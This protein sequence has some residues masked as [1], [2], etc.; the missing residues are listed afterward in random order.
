MAIYTLPEITAEIALWKSALS[1]IST[2]GQAYQIG[3]RS[4]TRADLAEIRQ[5][6]EWLDARQTELT[7]GVS[8]GLLRVTGRVART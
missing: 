7:N 8:G 4:L 5:H 1:A 2:T 6:L 3:G